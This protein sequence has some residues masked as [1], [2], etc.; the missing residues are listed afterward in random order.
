MR[1]ELEF[2]HKVLVVRFDPW[3]QQSVPNDM[4]VSDDIAKTLFAANLQSLSATV[5]FG[6]GTQLFSHAE[7]VGVGIQWDNLDNVRSQQ[8][9]GS[10]T[11]D[12]TL[13]MMLIDAGVY[14]VL[15]WYIGT[16]FPGM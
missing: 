5:A 7:Q 6:H 10:F 14:M 3:L 1:E 12:W 4:A 16:V 8:T 11:V 9:L 15:A 2:W 13:Y